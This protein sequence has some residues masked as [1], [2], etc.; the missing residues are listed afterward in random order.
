MSND[1]H[2]LHDA[3]EK[4]FARRL[5]DAL[6]PMRGKLGYISQ[7]IEGDAGRPPVRAHEAQ[8]KPDAFGDLGSNKADEA[9]GHNQQAQYSVAIKNIA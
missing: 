1:L 3:A 8:W 6:P 9:S 5:L 2:Q 7:A 4:A